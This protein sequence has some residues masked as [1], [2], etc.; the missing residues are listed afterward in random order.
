MKKSDINIKNV[1]L[2]FLP[3]LL[4]FILKKPFYLAIENRFLINPNFSNLV[5]DLLF[6]TVIFTVIVLLIIKFRGKNRYIPSKLEFYLLFLT[7][8]T[9]TLV[10]FFPSKEWEFLEIKSISWLVRLDYVFPIYM[11]LLFTLIGGAINANWKKNIPDSLNN[12]LLEDNPRTPDN[13]VEFE[14][15]NLATKLFKVISKNNFEKSFSIGIIGPWGNGKSSLLNFISSKIT[16]HNKSNKEK[17]IQVHFSPYLIHSDDY[18]RGFLSVLSQELSPYNGNISE[19][20]HRYAK[21]ISNINKYFKVIELPKEKDNSS[22]DLYDQ[23]NLGIERINKKIVVYLDDLDRLDDKEILQ[24][25]KLIRNSANFKNTIFL[26]AMDKEYILKRLLSS[27]KNL[28]IVFIDKFFQLEVYLPQ[29]SND[30]LAKYFIKKINCSNLL[31]SQEKESIID[32]LNHERI[33]FKEYV[34]NFRDIKKIFNQIV[35]ETQFL[36]GEISI[37]DLINFILLKT[38][39]PTIIPLIVKNEGYFFDT[40]NGIYELR[41]I[42]LPE[43][44]DFYNLL[45]SN[46]SRFKLNLAEYEIYSYFM[47]KDQEITNDITH[48]GKSEKKIILATLIRLFGDTKPIKFSSIKHR[49]NFRKIMQQKLLEEDVSTNEFEILIKSPDYKNIIKNKYTSIKKLKNL[50]TRTEYYTSKNNIEKRKILNIYS[51]LLNKFNEANDEDFDLLRLIGN[52][53]GIEKFYTE[54]NEY[55]LNDFFGKNSVL[56]N[57]NKLIILGTIWYSKDENILW[58]IDSKQFEE[59]TIST[60]KRYLDEHNGNS[61]WEAGD[62]S[63]FRVYHTIKYIDSIKKDRNKLIKEFWIE[64]DLEILFS[65]MIKMS[66]FDLNVYEIISVAEEIFGSKIDFIHFILKHRDINTPSGAEISKYLNLSLIINFKRN[67]CFKFINNKAILKVIEKNQK[68]NEFNELSIKQVFFKI[69]SQE[70]ADIIRSNYFGSIPLVFCH[71]ERSHYIVAEIPIR[72]FENE[73]FNFTKEIYEIAKENL[74]WNNL[75]YEKHKVLKK[76][77]FILNE[78]PK[79]TMTV[80]SIQP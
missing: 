45:F 29:I 64:N 5:F 4:F 65:Q 61:I 34:K 1:L 19:L 13:G 28:N 20:F 18:A 68:I 55:L 17:I 42:E 54:N 23:I 14:N 44:K 9:L 76:E 24:I 39:F 21:S 40:K 11:I 70:L 25:L 50:I 78:E 3:S 80:Y 48:L 15:S 33:M 63:F 37:T 31:N 30:E 73:L 26:V 62:F 72:N 79:A 41:K 51:V 74:G 8:S 66:S 53:A 75:N 16:S 38:K 46:L 58:G 71:F 35:F 77:I 36:S 10:Y 27:N 52:I 69:N 57:Y 59:L 22:T 32:S 67:I 47:D 12:F 43:K 7:L 60:F 56:S 2:I 49:S 6:I